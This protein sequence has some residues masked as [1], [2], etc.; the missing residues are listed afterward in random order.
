MPS[1]PH[2]QE[3]LG[4]VAAWLA[5]LPPWIR[6]RAPRPSPQAPDDGAD[7]SAAPGGR[8]LPAPMKPAGQRVEKARRESDVRYRSIIDTAV[9][10]VITID[11]NGVMD[12][13]NSASERMFGYRAE[14]VLG[15]NVS[16]L[17]PEPFRE[18]HDRY[19]R[20]Y[21]RTGEKKIIGIGREV[22]G[23]RK[24][25][26]LIPV[27]LAVSEFTF[28]EKRMF[29]GVLRDLSALQ[30]ARQ[31]VEHSNR[32]LAEVNR[33]L[34]AFAYS[35]SHD[36]RQP[37]RGITGFCQILVEDHAAELSPEA[38]GALDTIV[39]Q[40]ER[41]ASLIDEL[42]HLSRIAR[43]E[44]VRGESDLSELGREILEELQRG[45]PGRRVTCT[46]QAPLVASC[47]KALLRIALHNLIQNAWKFTSKRPDARIAVGRRDEAGE[48]VYYVSDN[49]AGFDM[50]YADKLFQAFQR[51]HRQGEFEGMGIG[52]A[53]V[54]RIIRRHGGRIWARSAPGQGCTFCFT[55]PE[56]D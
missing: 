38:R 36:L 20:G 47:D 52:L 18:E 22:L 3:H 7:A 25:G 12:L 34:E 24:D 39:Q 8:P 1:R 37:L 46:V 9:D 28:G 35:V 32:A 33:E 53:I 31:A 51:L 49:G 54:Q 23:L 26:G 19:I 5:A 29:A 6:A 30:R 21:L 44:L 16:M 4:F 13:F 40:A 43:Q 41:M 48:R 55:L 17:M 42:L 56:G 15:R 11:S 10:G 50:R 2:A 27:E 14:E 45:D